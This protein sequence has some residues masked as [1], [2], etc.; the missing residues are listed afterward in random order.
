MERTSLTRLLGFA[1]RR[2][3]AADRASAPATSLGEASPQFEQSRLWDY[4]ARTV[5]RKLST[6]DFK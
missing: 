5:D 4:A 2:W 6:A 1:S 3:G